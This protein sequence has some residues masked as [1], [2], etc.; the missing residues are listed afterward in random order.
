MQMTRRSTLSLILASLAQA[1][2]P[3]KAFAAGDDIRHILPSATPSSFAVSVSIASPRTQLD[4]E[5]GPHKVSGKRQDSL[6]RF[7]SFHVEGL[8]A[9]TEYTLQLHDEDGALGA[10]WPLRTFPDPNSMPDSFRLMAFTCAGG[11]DGFATPRRQYFKPHAFRQKLFD[12]GLADKPDAAIAIGDHIYWDLRGGELPMVSRLPPVIKQLAGWYLKYKYGSFDRSQP[13]LGT[14]NETTLTTVG[15]DQIANLYGTRFKSTPMFFVSDDHDFFENDDAEEDLVTFP[16]DDFSRA[17][18]K[19]VADLYYPPLLDGPSK[20][21]NRAFGLLRY[22]QLYEAALFD[23]AG[24]LT[25]DGD[26]AALVPPAIETWLKERAATSPAKHFSFV[27]SHPMGWTAGK[28][29]EW[30]PD[31]VAPEG[32]TGVVMNELGGDGTQGR[33]TVEA[34]KYLWPKGWW[35]QHQR[36]LNALA[37]RQGHR[38]TFSG[39]IHAQGAVEILASGSQGELPSPIKSILVG[40]VSTSDAT[41]PSFARGIPAGPPKW[42]SVQELVPTREVNGYTFFEFTPTSATA[43][44]VDCGGYDRSLGETGGMKS[45]N[46]IMLL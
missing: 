24:H 29:R 13:I 45:V 33:L 9:D 7:W 28:W 17:A 8:S 35:L 27:P 18:F 12:T 40:P 11:A 5:V 46:D 39:D 10:S 38:F 37:Q 36:L 14:Q 1:V 34:K 3:K 26:G 21:L 23:C 31:V 25:I 20:D 22:G 30:Y 15:D 43:R 2:V 32:F 16:A 42:L 41:W 19:A 44:L 4:L 6:G